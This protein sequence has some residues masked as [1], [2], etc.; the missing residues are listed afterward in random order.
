MVRQISALIV[1][2]AMS[3]SASAVEGDQWGDKHNGYHFA[4]EVLVGAV[5]GSVIDNKWAAFAVAMV[6]GIVREEWK[7]ERGY[8]SYSVPRL[9]WDALGAYVGVE[10]GHVLIAP[11]RVVFN[12]SF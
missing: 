4:G 3:A 10:V 8:S 11:N 12:T 5:A 2:L 9:F 1:A 7:R 6:P